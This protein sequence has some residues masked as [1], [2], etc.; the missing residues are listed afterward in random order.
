MNGIPR[1]AI[2]KR[3]A[4]DLWDGAVVNLG[5]GLPTF[6]ANFVPEGREIVYHSENGV[7]GVGPTPSKDKVDPD[8]INA[9][10]T[11]ISLMP[12]ASIFHHTDAFIM[13]R[14]GHIDLA[15][16]GA[17]Q[18]SCD[19]D[20]ANWSTGD[21]KM[22]PAVGGAMDLA[23]GAAEVRVLMEHTTKDGKPKIVETCTYPLTAPRVVKRIY[24]NLAVI[25]VT[26]AGLVVREVAD[27]VAFDA[28]QA[29]T[30]AKLALAND[31]AKL[32]VN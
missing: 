1:D 21:E 16:L 22:P 23:A 27:G 13:I 18:V 24:T 32:T 3:A 7:L 20:L 19:G 17:M 26:P 29:A 2:A 10:K 8:L 9:S 14:G 15:L 4:R 28:L 12:G 5:I 11:P 25:D 6:V 31:W 30:G